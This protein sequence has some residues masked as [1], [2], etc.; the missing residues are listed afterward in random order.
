MHTDKNRFANA[1]KLDLMVLLCSL[2]R[3]L[4]CTALRGD[5]KRRNDIVS[6]FE[7][8]RFQRGYGK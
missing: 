1:A 7:N 5:A 8:R 4:S 2:L 6:T 3:A